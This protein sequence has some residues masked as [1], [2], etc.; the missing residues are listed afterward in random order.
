MLTPT[1]GRKPDVSHLFRCLR[2]AVGPWQKNFAL[3]AP[4][5]LPQVSLALA[6]D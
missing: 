1:Q 3:A 5:R 4:S 6:V 2:Y